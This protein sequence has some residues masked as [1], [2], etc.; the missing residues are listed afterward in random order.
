LAAVLQSPADGGVLELIVRRPGVGRREVLNEG[1][2]DLTDGLVGDTWRI[3]GSSD[4]PDKSAHPDMQITLMNSRAS[5]LVAQ[6]QN[7]WPLAGDQLYL[8][9][10]VSVANL[11]P[12]TQLA[13]GAALI[14]ITAPPHTGCKK[15]KARFG[16]E[17]MRFVNSPRGKSLRLRGAN[18]KVVRAGVV[19]VGD[20]ARKV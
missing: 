2:L 10:D 1:M 6:D 16:L 15:F 9:L 20:I 14:E 18:A 8:D 11:P 13:V 17:A 4:T 3:R 19:R 7:R 5:A 12:G